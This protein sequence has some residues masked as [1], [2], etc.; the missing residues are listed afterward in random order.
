MNLSLTSF[1]GGIKLWPGAVTTAW[2]G[3][4]TKAAAA[5]CRHVQHVCLE[6]LIRCKM[7]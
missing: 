3:W 5:G 2:P 7:R 4:R 6:V 1:I